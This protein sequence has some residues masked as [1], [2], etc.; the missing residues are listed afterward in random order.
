M[1]QFFWGGGGKGITLCCNLYD[2]ICCC[3]YDMKA[4]APGSGLE[5]D[6]PTWWFLFVSPTPRYYRPCFWWSTSFQWEWN[7]C[8]DCKSV[9]D[10]LFKSL[11]WSVISIVVCVCV[12]IYTQVLCF[13]SSFVVRRVIRCWA[14]QVNGEIYNHE[15][16]RKNLPNHE[17]RT[18]SDCDVIAHLV[19]QFNPL[20]YES[21][22]MTWTHPLMKLLES[23]S[24][25]SRSVAAMSVHKHNMFF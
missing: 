22:F 14:E 16:L 24:F 2:V 5:W 9:Y 3:Y 13:P 6:L 8:C 20:L 18:G 21:V 7:H 25:L 17:F 1:W 23:I 10:H 15:E 4:E 11:I 12:Y 19:C